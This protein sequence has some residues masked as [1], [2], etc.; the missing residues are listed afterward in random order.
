MGLDTPLAPDQDRRCRTLEAVQNTAEEGPRRGC[1]GGTASKEGTE[2]QMN[3]PSKRAGHTLGRENDD[4]LRFAVSG[5]IIFGKLGFCFN[6]FV[7][8]QTYCIVT[9][10]RACVHVG[11]RQ[12]YGPHPA[13]P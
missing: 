8:N 11:I 9:C 3:T 12:W 6:T 5:V 4:Q 13:S 7:L 1:C 10:W 2:R